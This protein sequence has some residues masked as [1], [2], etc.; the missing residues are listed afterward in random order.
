MGM[1][2]SSL[3]F[4]GFGTFSG[5]NS[6]W[7]TSS[8]SPVRCSL[9]S[10]SGQ[11]ENTLFFGISAGCWTTATVFEAWVFFLLCLEGW[12]LNSTQ[13]SMSGAFC[14]RTNKRSWSFVEAFLW[15]KEVT[16]RGWGHLFYCTAL[17]NSLSNIFRISGIFFPGKNR[18][19]KETN[20]AFW[21]CRF[22]SSPRSPSSP[23]SNSSPRSGSVALGLEWLILVPCCHG[24]SASQVEGQHGQHRAKSRT[25]DLWCWHV[26]QKKV[27]SELAKF[28]CF[29][30][31]ILL[32]M[33]EIPNNHL[34]CMK[35]L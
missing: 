14:W 33:E 32:L 13:E 30:A 3:F 5:V 9:R 23:R 18:S 1:E 35:A 21:C 34:T 19:S 7:K 12:Q 8:R 16:Q 11:L 29:H 24:F 20:L 27:A 15:Q 10:T 22:N 4:L 28:P 25:P 31:S 2:G 6:R 26:Q 17:P